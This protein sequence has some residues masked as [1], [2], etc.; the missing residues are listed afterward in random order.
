M[1]FG[2][3]KG[4][5]GF[6]PDSV[7]EQGVYP[8]LMITSVH[9]FGKAIRNEMS[10][11]EEIS[12]PY[13]SNFISIGYAAL[14]FR[15]PQNIRY[16]YQLSGVTHGWIQAGA[17]RS[18]SFSNLAPGE[19]A[20]RI[21]ATNNN[22][23][24]N[25]KEHMITIRIVP[26]WYMTGTFRWSSGIGLALLLGFLWDRRVR[27]LKR[28]ERRQRN[29]IEA[30]LLS[31]RL[32]INPHFF[33]NSLNAI[34][35]FVMRNDEERANEYI[36][37]FARLM[38]MVL[39]TSRQPGVSI[40]DEVEMLGLYLELESVRF[41]GRF[42]YRIDVSE[43]IDRSLVIPSMMIQPYAENAV[44][45]GLQ[46][47][48]SGGLLVVSIAMQGD[49]LFC[50]VEDNGVGRKKAEELHPP[51]SAGH[52]PLGTSITSER[53]EVLNQLRKKRMTVRTVDLHDADGAASGTRVEI[54]IPVE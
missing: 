7:K 39:E 25:P 10:S 40:G 23:E 48:E 20:L 14:E 9:V 21:R 34:Q 3:W 11:G 51:R 8:P 29:L 38:R 15:K 36:A 26:P 18:C 47:R 6:H 42:A 44:R 13:A 22:G 16:M 45:H 17:A 32:Q 5:Y 52:T 30:E 28:E 35:S 49:S 1:L 50:T 24:W 43:E 31:L 4:V 33:F 37:T 54:S 27:S 53:L 46:H 2:G 41:S 19:Y 12:I